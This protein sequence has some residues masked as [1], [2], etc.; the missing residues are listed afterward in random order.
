M[1]RSKRLNQASPATLPEAL[2][3]NQSRSRFICC[4]EGE[5]QE[6]EVSYH[7]LYER[8]L[9]VL[10]YFQEQGLTPGSELMLLLESDQQFM[11]AF[12]ACQLGGII[13]I[14]VA[15][16]A[17]PE[18]QHRIL[19]IFDT[20]DN[21]QLL[22]NGKIMARLK[23]YADQQ[24][25]TDL[26][27]WI[28]KR[29]IDVELIAFDAEKGRPV[30][31]DPDDTALVQFSSGSTSDPKG[32]ILSHRN[33]LSNILAIISAAQITLDDSVL[34]WM[35]LTHDM[36]IIGF[37][38]VPLVLGINQYK[39]PPEVFARRPMLW[40]SKASEKKVTLLSSP[41]FGY[42]HFL[43]VFNDRQQQKKENPAWD[44]DRVR[45][46]FN[47]AEPI[48]Q[49]LSEEFCQ[50][51]KPFGL[52][53]RVMYPVYGLAEASL[54]ATFSEPGTGLSSVRVKRESLHFGASVTPHNNVS[55]QAMQQ[56][57]ESSDQTLVCLGH[58]VPDC[59]VRITNDSDQPLPPDHLG[60]IQLRGENVTRGYYSKSN[61]KDGLPGKIPL[62]IDDTYSR[63]GWLNTGDLGFFHQKNLY[64][65]GR[66]KD[67]IIIHGANY[68]PVDLEHICAQVPGV[69][70]D[71]VV[72]AGNTDS[73]TQEEKLIVFLR[74]RGELLKFLEL[75]EALRHE[76]AKQTLLEVALVIPVRQIPRTTSGK[77]QRYRLLEAL[78]CG[79]F[80]EQLEELRELRARHVSGSSSPNTSPMETL[81]LE[82][83]QAII[84]DQQISCDDNLI[85]LGADSLALVQLL[86]EIDE[87]YPEVLE[88]TDFLDY[89]SVAELAGFLEHKLAQ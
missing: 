40:M 87:R 45:L 39:M 20:L 78:Q 64:V 17:S 72:C 76:V 21:A 82:I 60:H 32:V 46:I 41:N 36:G 22:T 14:P 19:R 56:D 4:I 38:L 88:I 51:M 77:V 44:L 18:H 89:Q 47:G 12:W 62:S 79:E 52:D 63:D 83:V 71:T 68:F 1:I 85:D 33:L 53:N 30:K 29:T 6:T 7:M 28:R 84:P 80:D 9:G 81:L 48:S 25:L 61:A 5:N 59:E 31:P 11:D 75:A 23:L 16:G 73:N 3:M 66:A 65:T 55:D 34:S 43:K 70:S 67:T 35:P 49:S 26:L 15:A 24:N 2:E 74:H 37:H 10:H 86:E 57:R 42:R 54:A 69:E 8:A 27:Q 58:P 13:P 50:V